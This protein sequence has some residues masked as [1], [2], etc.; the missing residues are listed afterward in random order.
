MAGNCDPFWREER[1]LFW[2]AI[3]WAS[4]YAILVNQLSAHINWVFLYAV[5]TNQFTS[6]LGG[7][8]TR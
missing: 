8:P 1:E 3:N 6:F 4:F 7:G 5:L 2:A